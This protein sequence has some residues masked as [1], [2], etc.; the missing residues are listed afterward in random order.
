[1]IPQY[2]LEPTSDSMD[3]QSDT[4]S[5]YTLV[6]ADPSHLILERRQSLAKPDHIIILVAGPLVLQSIHS[7]PKFILISACM[8]TARLN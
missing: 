2:S 8:K 6:D 3:N 7:T 5:M 4:M 1:M